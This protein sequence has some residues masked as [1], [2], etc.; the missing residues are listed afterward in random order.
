M[1]VIQLSN[2]LT[3]VKKQVLAKHIEHDEIN[4]MMMT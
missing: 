1:N 4:M 3:C 2:S